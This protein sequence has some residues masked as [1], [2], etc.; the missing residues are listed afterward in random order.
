MDGGRRC[1]RD[2]AGLPAANSRAQCELAESES[3]GDDDHMCADWVE[4]SV[5]TPA[6]AALPGGRQHRARDRFRGDALVAA[7][8]C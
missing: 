8:G 3:A 2:P 1:E 6:T 4:A 5:N 7:G